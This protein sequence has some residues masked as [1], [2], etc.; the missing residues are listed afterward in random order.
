MAGIGVVQVIRD[1]VVNMT[2][3]SHSFVTAPGTMKVRH[4]VAR[5]RM[6]RSAGSGV[7][8]TFGNRMLVKVIAVQVVQVTIVSVINMIAVSYGRVAAALA[9]SV[10]M[11]L[12]FSF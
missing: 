1:Y 9:V 12:M 6:T 10:L 7:Q 8:G 2:A 5:T 11:F 4:L 3:M